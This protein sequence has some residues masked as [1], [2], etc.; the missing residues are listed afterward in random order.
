[1]NIDIRLL[2]PCHIMVYT[3]IAASDVWEGGAHLYNLVE[4]AGQFK[5]NRRK[6]TGSTLPMN[7]FILLPGNKR[8]PSKEHFVRYTSLIL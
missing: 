6:H 4:W 5:A 3:S 2:R 8:I 1:M 7:H